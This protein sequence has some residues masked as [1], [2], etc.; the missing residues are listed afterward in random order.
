MPQKL[1]QPDFWKGFPEKDTKKVKDACLFS[2]EHLSPI[3]RWSGENYAAHCLR[4]A[5]ILREISNDARLQKL[6]VLHDLLMHPDGK[7][8]LKKSSLDEKDRQ[9]VR[10]LHKLRGLRIDVNTR[11]LDF[12][13]NSFTEDMDTCLIRMAHRLAD[14]RQLDHLPEKRQRDMARETLHMYTALAGRLG[15]HAWRYE[16]EDK[17]FRLLYP[18]QARNLERQFRELEETDR[19]CLRETAKLL[20]DKLRAAGIRADID[21]RIKPL[22]SA[23]RKMAVKNR[24][25]NEL[26]DRLALRVIVGSPDECYR[27]LGIVHDAMRP[28]PGKLKDYIGAP[29]ANGYRSIHTVVYPLPGVTER[30]IEIQVRTLRM[31]DECEHGI[32]AHHNYKNMMYNIKY[33]ARARVDLFRNLEIIRRE[34]H[35]SKDFARALRNYF[36]GDQIVLF[37]SQNRFYHIRKPATALDFACLIH[38]EK[39]GRISRCLVNGREQKMD[40]LLQDGDTLE[41]E[42]GASHRATA[43]WLGHCRH[44][45]SKKLVKDLMQK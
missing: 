36:R 27:A 23:Y 10:T 19:V 45:N 11:D 40:Y 44:R 32:A 1:P 34:T 33:D 29:K 13:I 20:E 26:T 3:K 5:F 41:F 37:D 35:T 15:L 25:F 21:G 18:R 31:H 30:P 39:I 7:D 38:Q 6:A 9:V 22:Y 16:M 42:L 2:Y 12:V 17:C 28:I 4:V 43:A 24:A 8:L 14:V